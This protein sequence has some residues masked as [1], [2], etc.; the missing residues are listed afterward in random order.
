[1]GMV[2]L[3]LPTLIVDFYGKCSI[4]GCYGKENPKLYTLEHVSHIKSN[5]ESQTVG[6]SGC[7]GYVPGVCWNILTMLTKKEKLGPH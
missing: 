7:W 6:D 1:M 3:D 2:D 5:S 4:H